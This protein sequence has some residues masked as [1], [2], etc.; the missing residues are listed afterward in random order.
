MP[1]KTTKPRRTTVART[2]NTVRPPARPRA[3]GRAETLLAELAAL[4]TAD[5]QERERIRGELVELHLPL[6]RRE[7]RR[8]RNRGEPMDDLCQV[9][10]LGLM[11]A[12]RGF[13]PSFGKPFVAYLLPM[14]TGEL[15][16]HFR[17]TTWAVRVPR[18]HQ[19]KRSELNRVVAE[20]THKEGR[21][22][23]T[24]EIASA[25]ELDVEQTIELIDAASAYSAL[26]LDM[27]FGEADDETALGE[28][29]GST[30]H[31]LESVVDKE[32]LKGALDRLPERERRVVLLRFFGN[33]TQSEIATDVG[34]SQMHVSRLLSQTLRR[35]RRDLAGE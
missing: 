30:D 8:Y 4:K 9:G 31:A 24:K 26:S 1:G 19:E 10:T 13:D 21:T 33:K 14:V 12:I 32:A 11:K 18:A 17:D 16:R 27:P 25:L 2:K 20:F 3:T 22:P 28:T 6:V 5:V 15:K 35:M 23:T 29:L 34:L 7:A